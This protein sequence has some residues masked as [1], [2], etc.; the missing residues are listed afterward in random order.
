MQYCAVLQDRTKKQNSED[1]SGSIRSISAHLTHDKN[2]SRAKPCIAFKEE[3]AGYD[4]GWIY[5]IYESPFLFDPRDF[6]ARGRHR[7]DPE[8]KIWRSKDLKP[9]FY[10]VFHGDFEKKNIRKA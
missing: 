5:W 7:P 1:P 3:S 9:S 10:V 2:T 6:G 8:V 4:P